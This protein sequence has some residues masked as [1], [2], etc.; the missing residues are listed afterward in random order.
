MGIV[1]ASDDS[2]N[3]APFRPDAVCRWLPIPTLTAHSL[4]H[5]RVV[6]GLAL[7]Y[8]VFT[9][10]PNAQP[11]ELHRNYSWLA[12]WSLV[13]AVAASATAC[14]VLHGITLALAGLFIVRGLWTRP[15]YVAL[16]VS[17]FAVG[18]VDRLAVLLA[19]LAGLCALVSPGVA[20]GR[21][22]G[23]TLAPA[24]TRGLIRAVDWVRPFRPDA[25]CLMPIPTLTRWGSFGSC[26]AWRC[27]MSCS[28][29]RRARCPSNCTGITAGWRTGRSCTRWPRA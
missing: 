15:A 19:V 1:R 25:V 10:P 29:I 28:A 11:L 13:H 2:C 24:E 26:L 8:V 14:R 6:F 20:R 22:R 21:Y 9:D 7:F 23:G 3:N 4:G 12:D 5:F 18:L 17:I 27:S 16:V